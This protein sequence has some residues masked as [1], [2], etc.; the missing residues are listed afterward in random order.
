[1]RS[2]WGVDGLIIDAEHAYEQPDSQSP[3]ERAISYFQEIRSAYSNAVLAYTTFPVISLHQAFPY[4]VFGKYCDA[5]MHKT[6][7]LTSDTPLAGWSAR[8]IQI[9]PMHKLH[10]QHR[11]MEIRSSPSIRSHKPIAP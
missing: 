2:P 9:G 11:A 1:M 5:A 4:E 8:W 6:T 3:G 7:G 10:G